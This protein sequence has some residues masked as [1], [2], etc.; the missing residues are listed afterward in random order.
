MNGE[1]ST[2]VDKTERL[3]IVVQILI[4]RAV[5][6]ASSICRSCTNLCN[7]EMFAR[8]KAGARERERKREIERERERETERERERK[9]D[10][11]DKIYR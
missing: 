7:V 5:N 10:V 1:S 3:R 8:R 2:G 9:R 6:V 11:R 4:L